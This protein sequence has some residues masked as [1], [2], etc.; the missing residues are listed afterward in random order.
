MKKIKV[1]SLCVSTVM[2]ISLILTGCGSSSSA[3]DTTASNSVS[4]S[5]TTASDSS[6]A[7]D[8]LTGGKEVKISFLNSKGEID[9]QMQQAAK[10]FMSK[11]PNIT[12]ESFVA[13]AGTSPF[14]KAMSMYAADSAPTLIMMDG[15]NVPQLKDKLLDLSN[16]KWVADAAV[17]LDTCKA[18]GKIVTFPFAVEGFGLFYNKTLLAK[19]KVDPAAIKTTADLETAFKALEAASISPIGVGPMSWSVGDHFSSLAIVDQDKDNAVTDK[20]VENLKAGS[21]DL[22]KDAVFNGLIST[23]DLFAKYNSFKAD[24]LSKTYEKTCELFATGQFAFMFQGNWAWGAMSS[25]DTNN[26]EYGI[27]PVPVSNDPATYG[28]TGISAGVTKVVGID[29]TQNTEIQQQAARMFLNWLVYDAQGNDALVVKSNIIPAFKNIPVEPTDP[30][31]KAVQSYVKEGNTLRFYGVPADFGKNV[32]EGMLKYLAGKS[33]KA[34]LSK[35]VQDYW[36][37]VK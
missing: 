7:S 37:T 13:P 5:T 22:S 32:G 9:P 26:G 15:G 33:D 17:N 10:D 3:S 16:E 14:E 28:N 20:Y 6:T 25:F 24:P 12:V 21:I 27:I 35:T 8:D 4:T 11:Y 2:A 1:L 23:F 36:K 30:L 31:S 19:A 18:D 29:K 34:E